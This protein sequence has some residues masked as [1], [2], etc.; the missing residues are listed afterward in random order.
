TG[1][2]T[3]I[4]RM[5][6]PF[7]RFNFSKVDDPWHYG[8]SMSHNIFMSGKPLEEWIPIVNDIAT[9]IGFTI[10]DFFEDGKLKFGEYSI[11]NNQKFRKNVY[12]QLAMNDT[13]INVV[14]LHPA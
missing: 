6:D 12:A 13:Y 9:K 1:V 5:G 3:A 10:E 7:L 2:S 14:N 8:K 4:T 11:I